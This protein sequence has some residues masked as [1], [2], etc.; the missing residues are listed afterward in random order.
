MKIPQVKVHVDDEIKQDVLKVL[1]SGN[2]V[3]GENV[4]AFEEEFAKHHSTKYAVSVNSGTSALLLSLMALGVGKGDEVIMPSFSFIATAT[5]AVFLGAKPVFVD[6]ET[7]TYTIDVDCL[8][9]EIT[10]RTK[11]IIPVHLYGH[12][13][14][15]DI[16]R[17]HASEYGVPIVEDAC[18]AH[19]SEYK[20]QKVG[21]IG[22]L[23]CFSF[24]PSK[25]MTV[26]GD[27]GM[28]TTNNKELA[29]R[30]NMLRNCGRIEKYRHEFL[31][32]N[33][34]MSEISAAIGRQQLR[35]LD[36]WTKRRRMIAKF[37]N[38]TFEDIEEIQ[39]PIEEKWA[40]H[41]YHV[42][43]IRVD[44]RDKLSE[45][46]GKCGIA[47]NIHYPIPI[48][49]QPCMRNVVGDVKL[50]VTEVCADRVLSLPMHPHLENGELYYFS[51]ALRRYI[52]L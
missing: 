50:P 6:I 13:C 26:C 37:Y 43:T 7:D 12:P 8:R 44:E 19:S 34:R 30:I 36:A 21:S 42:Y 18:Q 45:Y 27:G 3:L 35:H 28:I 52:Y 39:T 9:D 20:G 22:D 4:K 1:D 31:S 2:Y 32:L 48:H 51:D 40:R 24:Y 17:A 29:D 33:F 38:K 16:I 11:A 41:V 46:L 10:K 5:P 14:D 47:T 49:K 15:M 23:G 25:N